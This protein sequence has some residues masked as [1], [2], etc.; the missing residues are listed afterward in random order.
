[1]RKALEI[2]EEDISE[3]LPLIGNSNARY[4]FVTDGL[5]LLAMGDSGE[6]GYGYMAE[7]I[8]MLDVKKDDLEYLCMVVKSILQQ[9]ASYFDESKE[10]I[11]RRVE[12][13]D[14]TPYICN[15]YVGAMVDTDVLQHYYAPEVTSLEG[16][17][18]PNC[19]T[20]QKVIF[21]NL[22]LN[23]GEEWTFD[24]CEEVVFKN[25]SLTSG[26]GHL[27]VT[28]AD[29]LIF[30]DCLISG[31]SGGFCRIESAKNLIIKNCEFSNCEV[32]RANGKWCTLIQIEHSLE[33]LSLTENKLSS[34]NVPAYKHDCYNYQRKVPVFIGFNYRYTSIQIQNVCIK[35]NTF[36]E[37]QVREPY[38]FFRPE[39]AMIESFE[40]AEL[41]LG[42]NQRI[43]EQ[44][45]IFEDDKYEQMNNSSTNA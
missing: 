21:E 8:E 39:G 25:C 12:G 32:G 36:I 22:V 11:T 15:Y 14:F 30:E 38:G 13:L 16:M 40:T 18:Y 41:E 19:F 26:V 35:N 34:C 9:E 6:N 42:G 31:F 45:R 29:K 7:L 3:F 24:G 23:I 10:M 33:N 44:T 4:Y 17:Q 43:G 20:E 5:L 28:Y 1:M 2:T 37:C 27:V